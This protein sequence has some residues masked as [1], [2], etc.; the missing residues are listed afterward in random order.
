MKHLELINGNKDSF[1]YHIKDHSLVSDKLIESVLWPS[2]VRLLFFD[3]KPFALRRGYLKHKVS[4][5]YCVRYVF[6]GNR[7][8]LRQIGKPLK[9]SPIELRAPRSLKEARDFSREVIYKYYIKPNAR[10]LG[11]DFERETKRY[12]ASFKKVKSA[13]LFKK[14]KTVGIVSLIHRVRSDGK[15]VSIVTW[16]WLDK[17]L[18][19]SEFSDALFKLGQWI[20]D[21]AR[22]T[23]AWYTHDFSVEEQKLC[24]KLGL[25]PYRIFFR[26]N[27]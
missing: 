25:K 24:S 6:G 26:R 21:N 19:V 10:L 9:D 23:V 12:L 8:D 13:L 1:L 7:K 27:K 4:D 11:P 16:E 17:K 2:P 18:P 14:D 20:R 22:E 3:F 15:P 5:K